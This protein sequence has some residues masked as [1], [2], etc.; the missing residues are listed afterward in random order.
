MRDPVVEVGELSVMRRELN[1]A[2]IQEL[3]GESGKYVD[4]LRKVAEVPTSTS[5]LLGGTNISRPSILRYGKFNRLEVE[6]MPISFS[7]NV[8][9]IPTAEGYLVVFPMHT[10]GI[11]LEGTPIIDPSS[12]QD[13]VT[14]VH[15]PTRDGGWT[16]TQN[17]AGMKVDLAFTVGQENTVTV[18]GMNTVTAT[19]YAL[20]DS[21][22]CEFERRAYRS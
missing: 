12:G 4:R 13:S 11:S 15:V 9:E 21:I 19:E 20:F 18:N 7:M 10:I 6:T 22:V 3:R 14:V 5:G 2:T 8:R 1:N 16:E 17:P